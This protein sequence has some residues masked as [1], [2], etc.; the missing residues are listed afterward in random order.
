MKKHK[1]MDDR[2]IAAGYALLGLQGMYKVPYIP[3]QQHERFK[4]CTIYTDNRPCYATF[5]TRTD[6]TPRN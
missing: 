6:R 2:E 4:Q 3:E 1:K 5:D